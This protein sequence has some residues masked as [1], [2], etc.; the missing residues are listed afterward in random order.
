M[1]RWYGFFLGTI[2]KVLYLVLMKDWMKKRKERGKKREGR[3]SIASRSGRG[4]Q[5]K[6]KRKETIGGLGLFFEQMNIAQVSLWVWL[7]SPLACTQLCVKQLQWT[8]FTTIRIAFKGGLSLQSVWCTCQEGTPC[9]SG[10]PESCPSL[11]C[12][13]CAYMFM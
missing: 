10:R 13:L 2:S 4:Y 5:G 6:R 1:C 8:I 3:G 11:I 7:I 12:I 9:I